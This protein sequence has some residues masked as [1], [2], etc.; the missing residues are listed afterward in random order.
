MLNVS[1]KS[2]ILSQYTVFF[3]FFLFYFAS[4]NRLLILTPNVAVYATNLAGRKIICEFKNFEKSIRNHVTHITVNFNSSVSAQTKNF[5]K[6][7]L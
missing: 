5:W 2:L 4:H 6:S 1:L 7:L 3:P